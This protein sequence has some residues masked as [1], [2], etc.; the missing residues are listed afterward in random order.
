MFKIQNLIFQ[1]ILDIP[2]LEIQETVTCLVGTSGSGKTTLLRMLNRLY[3]PDA[4]EIFYQ[5]RE[6]GSWDPVAL[7]REVV[8]LGQTPVIYNGT[9]EENLQMGRQFSQ[10]S[11]AG[12]THLQKALER[13][14][15]E[16]SLQ[17]SCR[18]FSGGEKQR[19]CL[20]RVMLMDAPVYLL[21]EPS[22][23]LDAG[24]EKAVLGSFTEFIREGRKQLVMV[25]HSEAL[26]KDSGGITIRLEKGKVKEVS[27]YELGDS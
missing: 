27:G 1:G 20:A 10:K 26:A 4:G 5:D 21:D 9:V 18:N 12:T 8:M 2:F 24:T 13:V 19:L 14:G 23:A 7:R 15:L 6:L 22:A 11:L 25:T 16:K 3:A 17:E